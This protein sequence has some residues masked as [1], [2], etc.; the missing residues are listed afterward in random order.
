MKSLSK[1]DRL[2]LMKFVC[3]F[4][5]ADLQVRSSER[6]MV[7]KLVKKLK[8]GHDEKQKVEEWLKVPPPADEV[9]PNNVPRAHRALFLETVRELISSDGDIDPAEAENYALFEQLMK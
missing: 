6:H 1:E 7:G 3:S 2:Q 4:A 5:W 9:D 8:L